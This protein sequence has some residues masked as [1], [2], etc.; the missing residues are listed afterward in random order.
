L[1]VS[2]IA[3]TL[4][5]SV[6]IS[7]SVRAAVTSVDVAHRNTAFGGAYESLEGIVHFA[8]DPLDEANRGIV[9]IGL[10]PRNK[11]GLVEFSANFYILQP[12]DPR[13][14]NG[15]AL[16]EVSNRGGKSLLNMFDFARGSDFGDGFLLKRGFTLA[17][18]GWE[19]DVPDHPDLLRLQAPV[20]TDRGKTI[21]GLVRSEWIGDHKVQT[22][23]LGDRTQ[24]GYSVANQNDKANTL[25]VRDTVT[26]T[27]TTLPRSSWRFADATHVTLDSGFRPGRLYD[28]VYRA[29]NPVVAGLGFAAMRDFVSSLRYDK[30]KHG[31]GDERQRARRTLAFGVSQDGRYLR[32]LLYQGFNTD[33]KGRP[34]F[35]GIWAHV[36]GA[37]RIELNAR[38]AQ[39]SRDGHPFM[40]VFYPVD[41]PPFNTD[42]LLA[43]ERKAE[44]VP[45]LFLSNGS[46]EY[47][48]RCA[49]L[50][51]T[52][53]DGQHDV[54]PP[55]GTRVYFFAGSQHFAGTIPPQDT[56]AQNKASVIDYRYGMRALLIAMQGWLAKDKKPPASQIPTIAAGQ[57]AT[58]TTLHFPQIPG[59]SPPRHK[60][61][62]Y[63]LDFR[64]QPPTVGLPFPTL[65]PQVDRDG[66]ELSGIRMPEVAVPLATYTGWNLRSPSI[67][68]PSEIYSM[69]GSWIPFPRTREDREQSH[70]PRLS[71][72]ERYAS[73]EDYL[74]KV[75]AAAQR[76]VQQGYVLQEDVPKLRERAAREWAYATTGGTSGVRSL[77]GRTFEKASR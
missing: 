26:G 41:I 9:D 28:V 39:P 73:E 32:T 75:S 31:F 10:A 53:E 67:G 40:N 2:L 64:T 62:A 56:P 5:L 34:V 47:W 4:L 46:Y 49:S 58:L 21:T 72:Q 74:A 77:A 44:T 50:T 38:F 14:A 13:N 20:A 43:P 45:K 3:R 23:S 59:V 66:N 55:S 48:G 35:D 6:L 25:Y 71:I 57:L 51:H 63:R 42:T 52:T 68:S 12:R 16:V 36:G 1:Q 30:L 54:P 65:V 61:E 70:D 24:T 29:K 8:V 19:F 60:R 37:G 69:I 76:L 7:S 17:W 18:I 33:E 11:K 27:R 22:I 15:T